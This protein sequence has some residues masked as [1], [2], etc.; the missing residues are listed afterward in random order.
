MNRGRSMPGA[1]F[2]DSQR[3]SCEGGEVTG[4]HWP[5]CSLHPAQA[6]CPAENLRRGVPSC[7][8]VPDP[9]VTAA[10]AQLLTTRLEDERVVDE[11]WRH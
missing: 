10:L 7:S 2:S 9:A 8:Q 6:G 5:C 4:A 3:V 1:T 11:S